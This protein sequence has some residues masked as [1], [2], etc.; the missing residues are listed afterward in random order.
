LTEDHGR[1]ERE[2]EVV[3][4]L[5]KWTAMNG[6]VVLLV[7]SAAAVSESAENAA[8]RLHL[9]GA[10]CSLR[11]L[12]FLHCLLAASNLALRSGDLAL[13]SRLM[14]LRGGEQEGVA[15]TNAT[16]HTRQLR[17][18]T[19]SR[20]QPLLRSGSPV[21]PSP[22]QR[23]GGGPYLLRLLSCKVGRPLLLHG[24]ARCR[25]DKELRAKALCSCLC[26]SQRRAPFGAAILRRRQ[27]RVPFVELD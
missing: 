2:D 17:R 21:G 26:R 4:L 8:R 12:P 11:Q 23:Y 14:A 25:R 19:A 1:V 24:A 16:M 9:V 3:Q 18:S 20:W 6:C 22:S 27:Q 13:S 10:N 5:G 7:P 15:E